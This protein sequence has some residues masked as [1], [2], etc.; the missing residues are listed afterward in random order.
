MQGDEND[1]GAKTYVSAL[2][3]ALAG[4]GWTEGGNLRLDAR[5]VG[6]DS[7]R[8]ACKVRAR[9]DPGNFR[10]NYSASRPD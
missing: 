6:G 2:T 3:Q 10:R 8:R 9:R 7:N 5:F 1:P 4:L